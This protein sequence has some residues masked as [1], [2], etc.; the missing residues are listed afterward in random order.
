LASVAASPIIMGVIRTCILMFWAWASCD[1]ARGAITHTD[2]E[3][4]RVPR[5]RPPALKT[6]TAH[7]RRCFQSRG[8][9]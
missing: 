5:G 6:A 4:R 8:E 2:S 7:Q 9:R 3:S 1:R